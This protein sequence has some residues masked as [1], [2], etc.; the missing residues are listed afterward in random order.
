MRLMM[1]MMT[2]HPVIV[3]EN[4]LGLALHGVACRVLAV[5]GSLKA[6]GGD[7]HYRKQGYQ[8]CAAVQ[9]LQLW[10]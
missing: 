6:C 10:L 8:I 7:L 3:D 1:T 9:F 2:W 5:V 4:F